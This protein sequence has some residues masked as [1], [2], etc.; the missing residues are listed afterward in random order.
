[1]PISFCSV[2]NQVS[3]VVGDCFTFALLCDVT[4][5]ENLTLFL[6][7]SFSWIWFMI[8]EYLRKVKIRIT[9]H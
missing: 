4:G 3:K 5:C 9:Y 7:Q 6:N 8:V 1:M 2:F